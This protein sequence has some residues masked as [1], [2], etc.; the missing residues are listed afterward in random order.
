[1]TQHVNTYI[2]LL[3][4]S[5][6]EVTNS[7]R[8]IDYNYQI[9]IPDQET[10]RTRSQKYIV[11]P[12]ESEY[13][14]NQKRDLTTG[15]SWEVSVSPSSAVSSVRLKWTG[16]N[17]NLRTERTTGRTFVSSSAVT[18][19]R[20][21]G[22]KVMKITSLGKSFSSNITVGDE[23]YISPSCGMS[24]PS[25]AGKYPVVGIENSGESV[26]VFAPDMMNDDFVSVSSDIYAFSSG[27]VRDGDFVKLGSAFAFS[28]RGQFKVTMVTSRFFEIQ[29]P[30][31]MNETVTQDVEIFDTLY[32]TTVIT[33][34]QTVELYVNDSQT[35]LTIEPYLA[36]NIGLVGYFTWRGPVYQL[37]VTNVGNVEAN[38]STFF[39]T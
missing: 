8:L 9:Q 24:N 16:I 1:M 25:D 32:K 6:G 28:N 29:N 21:T 17:P 18:L 7:P 26:L 12:S 27:P 3:C 19:M 2:S 15:A 22:S 39:S 34:D 38:V 33:T 31:Y 35:P 37:R 5:D 11:S 4:Y 30:N 20:V 13:V 36:G 14:L 10:S 23:L